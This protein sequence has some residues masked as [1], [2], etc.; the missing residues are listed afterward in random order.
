[1]SQT[2]EKIKNVAFGL[3]A[4][5]GYSNTTMNEIAELVGIKKASLYA[6]FKSKD[7]LFLTIYQELV[8]EFDARME[9]TAEEI[10]DLSFEQ[11]LYIG[12][13]KYIEYFLEDRKRVDFFYQVLYF[14][15]TN[16]Y[17]KIESHIHNYQ[18]QYQGNLEQLFEE[19]MTQ[20][21]IRQGNAFE[22]A[23]SYRCFREGVLLF[24]I[25]DIGFTKD[26]M[27]QVWD[28]YWNGIKKT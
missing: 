20:G 7:D 21:I 6:H 2:K 22:M 10:K 15:P 4:Q 17:D 24:L 13:E 26:K 1:M 3:F 25:L 28:N 18:Q 16:L 27:K 5:Y 19:G 12:Y 9:Q 8:A 23:I 11:K 14:K